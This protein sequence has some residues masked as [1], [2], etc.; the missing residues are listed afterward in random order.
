MKI[1][2]PHEN[3]SKDEVEAILRF[4]MEGRKRV[5]DQLMRIDSTYMR[6]R[7]SYKDLESSSEKF[8]KTLEEEQYPR[9]YYKD[10]SGEE[11]SEE[12][13]QSIIEPVPASSDNVSQTEASPQ[14]PMP[15]HLEFKENQRG[16]TFEALFSDYLRGARRIMVTDPYIRLFFQIR[17]F[18]EFV[19]TVLRIK[20]EDEE[21]HIH[22]V[23]VKDEFKGDLQEESFQQIK[24]NCAVAG[25]QFT[26]ALM[27][28]ILFTQGIS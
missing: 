28:P 3:A 17:N 21:V 13:A 2:F 27:I 18:M 10:S 6:V 23:T 7:F 11:S 9:Y 20:P 25:I 14:E 5:K 26:W 12:E 15:K 16:I 4:S 22:L 8:V 1:I 24:D 19:E